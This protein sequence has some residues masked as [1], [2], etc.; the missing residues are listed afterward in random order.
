MMC[1]SPATPTSQAK[2]GMIQ[3][4]AESA[5][6]SS[7]SE[8]IVQT[9]PAGGTIDGDAGDPEALLLR[10]QTGDDHDRALRDAQHF[11]EHCNQFGVCGTVHRWRV[12]PDEQRA[13][14]HPG[15][16]RST[17]SRH[18]AHADDDTILH[19]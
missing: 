13:I 5:A 10:G 19:G 12:Q 2:E 1:V 4:R 3:N 17:R 6:G 14:P 15:D 8:G 11:R 18:D 9:E 16:F 7:Q